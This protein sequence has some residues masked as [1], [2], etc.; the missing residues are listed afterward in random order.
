MIIVLPLFILFM[1]ILVYR[2]F[3]IITL[4][5]V[6]RYLGNDSKIGKFIMVLLIKK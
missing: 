5:D 1:T 2:Q 4:N 6:N 3:K